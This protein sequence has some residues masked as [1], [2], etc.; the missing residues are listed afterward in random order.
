MTGWLA[1]TGWAALM[2]LPIALVVAALTRVDAWLDRRQAERETVREAE[3]ITRAD[4][5]RRSAEPPTGGLFAIPQPP[6][7]D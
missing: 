7:E 2:V 3:A 1:T 5:A 4:A 6:E